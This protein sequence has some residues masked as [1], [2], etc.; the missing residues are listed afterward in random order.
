MELKDALIVQK[1][2][3]SFIQAFLEL[4]ENLGANVHT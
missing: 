3:P 1:S 2:G 4:E